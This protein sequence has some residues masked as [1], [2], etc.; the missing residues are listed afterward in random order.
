[1][2]TF[3][4]FIALFLVVSVPSYTQT[5]AIATTPAHSTIAVKV[6]PKKKATPVFVPNAETRAS[7]VGGIAKLSD[8][9]YDNLVYPELGRENGREGTVLVELTIAEN[10]DV[11]HARVMKGLGMGFDK[12]ALR[13]INEMPAWIPAQQG[14]RSVASK[15]RIPIAFKL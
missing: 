4:F 2:K 13:L 1:M 10:G 12:E 7:Y 6:S 3:L 14:V 5:V 8:Y 11:Q 9:L 15:V